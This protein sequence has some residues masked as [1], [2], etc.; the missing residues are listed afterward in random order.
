M[1]YYYNTLFK[2]AKAELTL[3]PPQDLS[4]RGVGTLSLWFHGDL[5]NAAVPMSVV[6]NGSSTVYHDDPDATRIDAWTQWP[7]DLSAFGG[8][9]ADL[10]NVS[11]IAI[12]FGDQSNIEAGGSGV[13]Y[14]DDIRLYGS[15]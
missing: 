15:K 6:L 2:F 1:P 3:D 4:D 11:S 8:F 13:M 12:C 9:G 7:I 10:V 14:F 5:S